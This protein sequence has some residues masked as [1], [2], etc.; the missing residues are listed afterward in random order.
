MSETPRWT[1]QKVGTFG[2]NADVDGP[3]VEWGQPVEVV[4]L[5]LLEE[6]LEAIEEE[7]RATNDRI[8]AVALTGIVADIRQQLSPD[9][10]HACGSRRESPAV[11]GN[12]KGK[13]AGGGALKFC[14]DSF[15]DRQQLF[16]AQTWY[17]NES[18]KDLGQLSP[19]EEK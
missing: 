9:L 10:C 17:S 14:A 11:I 16:P 8:C 15:H 3:G 12:V 18:A 13:G 19:E 2:G 6:A 5:S 7:A 1:I 4:P